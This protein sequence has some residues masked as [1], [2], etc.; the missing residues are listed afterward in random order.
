[1]STSVLFTAGCPQGST[2][3]PK[4]FNIYCHDLIDNIEGHLTLYVD[5]SYVIV[6]SPTP[7]DLRMSASS[8]IA[9]HHERLESNSRVCNIEKTEMLLFNVPAD[10]EFLV[11]IN[12]IEIKPQKVMKVLGLYF[13][14]KLDWDYQVMSTTKR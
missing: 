13:N 7:Q 5:D 12:D 3:G 9:K 8:T 2:L 4:V 14:S 10:D 6:N 1:M 11:K